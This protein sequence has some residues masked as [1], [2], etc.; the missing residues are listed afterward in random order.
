MQFGRLCQENAADMA[1]LERECFALPWSEQQCSSALAQKAFA[2][3]GVWSGGRLIA[4]VSFYHA[5]GEMDIINVAVRREWRRKGIGARILALV[6]Q[7]AAKMGMQRATLE[8]R[9]SNFAAIGLY[10]KLGFGR[11]GRRKRYYPDTGEDALVY[12][13]NFIKQNVL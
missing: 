6:L 8:V 1:N 9:C 13:Y 12:G 11:C 4:Y 10:E 7:A 2:A 3:F 5:A